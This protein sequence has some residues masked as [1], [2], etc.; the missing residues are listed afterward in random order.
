M[1]KI[2]LQKY[3]N[4]K[5]QIWSHFQHSIQLKS[6]GVKVT[7]FTSHELTITLEFLH[8]YK[9]IETKRSRPPYI[10]KHQEILPPP[11]SIPKVSLHGVELLFTF[12]EALATENPN[13]NSANGRYR[14]EEPDSF[15]RIP[16]KHEF[17]FF[18]ALNRTEALFPTTGYRL[19]HRFPIAPSSS[20]NTLLSRISNSSN[21]PISSQEIIMD[22]GGNANLHN[23]DQQQKMKEYLPYIDLLDCGLQNIFVGSTTTNH[24][25]QT[26]GTP[27]PQLSLCEL[28]PNIFIPSYRDVSAILNVP[29]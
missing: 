5:P 23:Q 16:K 6:D 15:E 7:K 22:Y 17:S 21:F 11:S 13:I 18:E 28:Y 25:T 24:R 26:R 1:L 3:A 27:Q 2:S 29:V 8:E 20:Q 14:R 19:G 4:W 10:A 12:S 9:D